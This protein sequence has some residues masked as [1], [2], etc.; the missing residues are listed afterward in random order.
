MNYEIQYKKRVENKVVNALSR[1][2]FLEE[3]GNS[4]TA[5]STVAPQWMQEVAG[6]CEGDEECE[7]LI[8]A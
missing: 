4:L 6:S 3:E 1:R 8:A 7:K 2:G 5:V